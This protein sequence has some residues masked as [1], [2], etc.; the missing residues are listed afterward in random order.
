MS[1]SAPVGEIGGESPG[2]GYRIQNPKNGRWYT[3]KDKMLSSIRCA[4]KKMGKGFIGRKRRCFTNGRWYAGKKRMEESLAFSEVQKGREW[5]SE[6][7]RKIGRSPES[8]IKKGKSAKLWWR[9]NPQYRIVLKN[10]NNSPE[11]LA[12][13][14]GIQDYRKIFMTTEQNIRIFVNPLFERDGV[15]VI[16]YVPAEREKTLIETTGVVVR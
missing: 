16:Q 14:V 6:M 5:N 12:G 10:R 4:R 15:E 1:R 7:L 8:H 9:N 2:R 3:S 11:H 13:L